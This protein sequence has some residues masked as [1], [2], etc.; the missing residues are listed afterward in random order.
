MS[1]S[2]EERD[3]GAANALAQ[4]PGH[5]HLRGASAGDDVLVLERAAHHH[6][7]VV[8]RP[9]HLGAARQRDGPAH[10]PPPPAD[11]LDKL[12]GAAAQQERAGLGFGAAREQVEAL[13]AHLPLLEQGARTQV[14][15]LEPVDGRLDGSAHG[16]DGPLQVVLGDAARAEDV[17][18]GKVLRGQ[19][20]DS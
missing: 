1:R 18:V 3:K 6:D 13:P 14:L 5:V 16:L 17:A 19:V 7:G 11:L 4:V 12:L 10:G 15:R 8:Q 20:A 2:R 9:L